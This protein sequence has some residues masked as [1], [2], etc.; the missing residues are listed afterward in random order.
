MLDMMIIFIKRAYNSDNYEIEGNNGH[1]ILQNFF[2]FFN[3][4]EHKRGSVM[5]DK[6]SD[7]K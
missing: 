5:S 7:Q 6:S 3:S 1:L 4:C 2:F